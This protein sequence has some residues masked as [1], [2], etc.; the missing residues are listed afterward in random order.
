M[1]TGTTAY[2][3]SDG[4]FYRM[5]GHSRRI[6]PVAIIAGT[7]VERATRYQI[8]ARLLA[9]GLRWRRL[10]AEFDET[11]NLHFVEKQEFY[12]RQFLVAVC[13]SDGV[14]TGTGGLAA[15]LLQECS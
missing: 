2:Q 4:R 7:V 11:V 8:S 9:A 15:R 3:G 1:S 10:R 14:R 13:L 12:R 6:R 5:H